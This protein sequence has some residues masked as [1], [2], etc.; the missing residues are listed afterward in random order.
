MPRNLTPAIAYAAGLDAGNRSRRLGNREFWNLDDYR[1][2]VKV[3]NDLLA[4]ID[5]EA[6]VNAAYAREPLFD[7]RD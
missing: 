2:A 1:E 5:Q 6:E 3:T 7:P 4:R